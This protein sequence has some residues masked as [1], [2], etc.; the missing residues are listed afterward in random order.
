M[1]KV[2]MPKCAQVSTLRILFILCLKSKVGF[3]YPSC[4]PTQNIYPLYENCQHKKHFSLV[5]VIIK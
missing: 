1:S 2:K 5:Q 3:L 4:H